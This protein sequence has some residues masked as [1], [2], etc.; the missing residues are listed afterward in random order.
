[1]RRKM[2]LAAL[3]ALFAALL[4]GCGM[5]MFR[6]AEELYAQPLLPERYK[7]LSQTIQAAMSGI[8]AEQIAPQ[9][10]SNTS[11]IQLL[12]LDGDGAEEAA[13]AFFRSTSSQDT[14]PLKIYLFQPG[15]D[16]VFQVAYILQGEGSNI[17]SIT[18]EDLD[19]DGGKEVVVSWQL[20][21]R[22][23][24]LSVYALHAQEADEWIHTTYNESYAL[25]DLDRDGVKELLI[26]QR[27][28]TG[29]DHSKVSW[30]VSQSE[31]LMLAS[32]ANLS[33]NITDVTAVRSSVLA[34]EIPALYVTSDCPD[35]RVTDI[36]IWQNGQLINA[37]LDLESGISKETLRGNPDINVTDIDGDG[38]LEIPI[39][40]PLPHAEPESTTTHWLTYWRQFNRHGKATSVCI[41]Y[42][43]SDGW[44][45]VLPDEWEG[46]VTVE[47][48]NSKFFRGERAVVFY[49]WKGAQA[50]RFMSIYRLTGDNRMA[51]ANRGNRQLLRTTTTTAYAVELFTDGWDCGLD[52]EQ[53]KERFHFITTEWANA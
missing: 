38:V 37:T 30:Y 7:N 14:Q 3:C 2:L 51:W 35:G 53:I 6:T 44:Y 43:S 27:D 8:D 42:H 32:A 1:M 20:T 40:V 48:N 22:A 10:G 34:G 11:A 13:A 9:S 25:A 4:S 17:N 26:I 36:F 39:S 31:T 52:A 5:S 18:Y 28:D 21:S 15:D 23:N 41:T 12:D 24:V 29:E 47:S 50:V 45:L 19:G 33:E 49:R 46:H 16:G